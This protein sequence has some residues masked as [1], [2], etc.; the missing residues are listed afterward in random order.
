MVPGGCYG[1]D[2]AS[3][4][5]YSTLPGSGGNASWAL[6]L[7]IDAAVDQNQS[8]LY[9]AMWIGVTVRSPSA[10]LGQCELELQLYPDS[11]WAQPTTTVPGAWSA[12]LV[13]WQVSSNRSVESLC[14][15]SPVYNATD[16]NL[17]TL[18]LRGGD[19]LLVNLTGWPGRGVGEEF[20][21]QD[22]SRGA[23]ALL[24]AYDAA[25]HTA[26][27]PMY[28][29]ESV[30]D[31][32]AWDPEG[33]R[34]ISLGFVVGRAA[35]PTVPRNSS[36][37]GCSPGVP[38]PSASDPAV[39]CPGYDP[40]S[41]TNK[42]ASPWSIAPP[43]FFGP[44][45]SATPGAVTFQQGLGGGP[46]SLTSSSNGVC[47]DRVGSGFC[48]YPWFSYSCSSGGFQFGA[49]DF[50]GT[51]EDF[52][53]YQEYPTVASVNAVGLT[54]YPG[55]E[56]AIPA[57]SDPAADL[58][59]HPGSG[60]T[61]TVAGDTV[62][63]ST[64][65]SGLR[66]ADYSAQATPASGEG[67]AGWATTGLVSVDR[68]ADPSATV[69]VAGNGTLSATFQSG[70][71]NVSLGWNSSGGASALALFPAANGTSPV[72]TIASGATGSV[73]AGPYVAVVLPAPGRVVGG[74]SASGPV[75]FGSA[76]GTLLAIDLSGAAGTASASATLGAALG[77][78][79]LIE[80]TGEGTVRV[81]GT[82]VVQNLSGTGAPAPI[83]V[84]SGA[85]VLNATAAPGWAFVGWQ[86]SP[87]LTVLSPLANAT[88]TMWV[89]V[90]SAGTVQA[91]FAAQLTLLDRPA[92]GGI[93]IGGLAPAWNNTT[94]ELVPGNYSLF[95][96]PAAGS[97][98]AGWT[99]SNASALVVVRPGFPGTHVRVLGPGALSAN[100]SVA[101]TVNLTFRIAPAGTGTIQFNYATLSA[102]STLNGSVA[103][104]SYSIKESPAPGY[105]FAGWNVSG[106]VSVASGVLTVSGGGGV[107]QA[108]FRPSTY[109]VTFVS[110]SP[111]A[112]QVVLNGSSLASGST[113]VIGKGTFNLSATPSP[114]VTF[115][116]WEVSG[117]LAVGGPSALS[118]T[119][120]VTG[121]GTLY[122]LV[123]PFLVT[124]LTSSATQVDVGYPVTF[125]LLT[126]GATPV[127]YTWSGL[128]ADCPGPNTASV[129]CASRVPG[130]YS[131]SVLVLGP[132]QVGL[133]A[134]PVRL[135]VA[136]LPALTPLVFSP[137]QTDAGLNVSVS[138]TVSGGT[139]PM[140]ANLS[141][142][143]S[144]ALS[145][146]AAAGPLNFTCHANVPENVT[147]TETVTDSLGATGS[148]TGQLPIHPAMLASPLVASPAVLDV[149]QNWSVVASV[150]G[151]S[152]PLTGRFAGLP[153]GC[154][155]ADGFTVQCRPTAPSTATIVWTV[156]DAVGAQVFA[157]ANV[158]VHPLPVILSFAVGPTT[159]T[160]G[161]PVAFAVAV[162]GGT[163]PFT[164]IYSHL[165]AG[166]SP[167][168]LSVLNCT[169]GASGSFN[170]T[171]EVIDLTGAN[172]SATT[173]LIVHPSAGGSPGGPGGGAGGLPLWLIV[174]AI[175]AV[176]A[177]L[178]A[179]AWLL[180]RRRRGSGQRPSPSEPSSSQ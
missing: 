68:P 18:S 118:T 134:G 87:G 159:V 172:A 129:V 55:V 127:G 56:T 175:V 158:T 59:L 91:V 166:C 2:S 49:T 35:D 163:G 89:D 139:G 90:G 22:R 104:G 46:V 24:F 27:D 13:G 142:S 125:S 34:P 161:T 1:Y 128:P 132:N 15:Y 43:T 144:A 153:A 133:P 171:V 126:V 146:Q 69:S 141:W 102:P 114:N 67:F 179:T 37:A 44:A 149:G 174:L 32:L 33:L 147:V 3:I 124:S 95:A 7:P 130:A 157:W 26:L 72:A 105:R 36:S 154:A 6:T 39:P 78:E 40:A 177:A 111:G 31:A 80:V 167:M 168:N 138:S 135:V 62:G 51:S 19:Q 50:A 74:V 119:V 47:Q 109:A 173:L 25:N 63:S 85:T 162:G 58:Q 77:G 123:V 53:Q 156:T 152:P 71:A 20:R 42:T 48:S 100:Y 65:L 178:G 106:P 101:G 155:S 97:V 96:V 73:P 79:A 110:T 92:L 60:G 81:N 93:A 176:V 136:R 76:G 113:L 64:T 115:L 143:P 121:P 38:P 11:S 150:S 148:V 140:S 21:L 17:S 10:W 82:I 160:V 151:G 137:P 88:A 16:G 30:N 108:K 131:V 8:S 61:V 14:F 98:F 165:P 99:V 66:L 107:V 9:A 117:K 83:A 23:S 84:D 70:V 28:S 29:T 164:F 120:T 4:G 145:C 75:Q 52:G 54:F 86:Y 122:A 5:F 180:R 45:G 103:I 12:A 169:P 116:G 170:V 57:C 41:W 112:V 94:V